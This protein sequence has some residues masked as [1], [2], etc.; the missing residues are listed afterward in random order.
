[1]LCRHGGLNTF[2]LNIAHQAV[3]RASS[4]YSPSILQ[5]LFLNTF[6]F[7][8]SSPSVHFLT[9]IV[10]L[11]AKE[12]FFDLC[13]LMLHARVD[14]ESFGLAVAEMS[15]RNKPVLTYLPPDNS[16]AYRSHIRYLGEKG[17]YYTTREELDALLDDFVVNGVE[18][19][20]YNAYRDFSPEKVMVV[21]EDIFIKPCLLSAKKTNAT[22]FRFSHTIQEFL[23]W[24]TLSSPGVLI[25]EFHHI[26]EI[27]R[28]AGGNIRGK[29][30]YRCRH[31]KYY[32]IST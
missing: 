11:A 21:F 20:D 2:N 13:D 6:P 30:T 23:F 9:S 27:T 25:F 4:I 1:M 24:M 3:K 7:M 28:S 12:E 16:P 22:S 17:Y 15:I 19:R 14:G 29:V 8:E 32:S 5:F 10:D 18:E 31:K 26:D